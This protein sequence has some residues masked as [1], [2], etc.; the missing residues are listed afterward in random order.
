M[1]KVPPPPDDHNYNPKCIIPLKNV[2]APPLNRAT[3]SRHHALWKL[4]TLW[5]SS[6]SSVFVVGTIHV[7]IRVMTVG[8]VLSVF[9]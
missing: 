6:L 2:F 4:F 8:N 9:P 3:G 7:S 1:F 5:D